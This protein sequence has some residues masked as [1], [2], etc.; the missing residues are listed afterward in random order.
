[1]KTAKITYQGNLRTEVTHLKSGQHF[2]TDA[3]T[4]NHGLGESISPTDMVAAA[5][6][7]C[8]MTMM[9]I[10]AQKRSLDMGQVSGEVT[11]RMSTEGA[12]RIEGLQI[13][14]HFQGHALTAAQQTVLENVALS[15]PVTRSLHPDIAVNLTFSYEE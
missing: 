4:D 9:G 12:R 7:S 11:K 3:P 5:A 6:V 1:M 14:L 10:A 8:M 13:E 2:L 15:C